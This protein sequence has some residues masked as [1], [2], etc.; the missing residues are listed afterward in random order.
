MYRS[1]LV[2]VI[3]S[4]LLIDPK[5]EACL[6]ISSN[7]WRVFYSP[8]WTRRVGLLPVPAFHQ[9]PIIRRWM[10]VMAEL[11]KLPHKVVLDVETLA[12]E[13]GNVRASNIVM[14]G[15]FAIPRNRL[16]QNY[17][18]HSDDLARKGKETSI[19]T[20]KHSRQDSTLP[21][22]ADPYDK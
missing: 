19:W 13:A 9:Y 16:W 20:W 21:T 15:C 12:K 4:S 11:D 7:R 17:W 10:K 22:N 2:W 14:L 3:N 6:I 18:W 1:N 8:I 5:G